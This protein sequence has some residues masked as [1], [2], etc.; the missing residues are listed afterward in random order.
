MLNSLSNIILHFYIRRFYQSAS[1]DFRYILALLKATKGRVLR[2]GGQQMKD[3]L[4]HK[5]G[6][7]EETS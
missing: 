7:P 2:T 1:S 4:H 5:T 6:E 3:S